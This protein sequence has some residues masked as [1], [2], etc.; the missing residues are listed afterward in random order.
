MTERVVE[1]LIY[2]MSELRRSQKSSKKLDLLSKDLIQKGYTESEIS[3]ALTWIINRL[4]MDAEEVTDSEHPN[5][6]AYRHLHEIERAVISTEA[7]GYVIQLKELGIIDELD[8]E[9]LLERAMMLGTSAVDVED[10]KSIVATLLI[11]NDGFSEGTY[12]LLEKNSI[13]Q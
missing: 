12:F 4:N 6:N 9:E 7:Y 13:I 11:R 1:I 8:V 5:P 3:S 2:I 10:I